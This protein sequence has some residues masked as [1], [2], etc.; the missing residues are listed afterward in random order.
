[1]IFNGLV[2]DFVTLQYEISTYIANAIRNLNHNDNLTTSVLILAISFIYGVVHAAGP[3]HG[4]AV[5]AFYFTSNKGSYKEA[6]KIGYMISIIHAISGLVTTFAIYFTMRAFFRQQFNNVSVITMKISA[7]LIMLIGLY[8]IYEAYKNKKAKENN[9]PK[10]N[11]SKF[12]VALS[13][14]IVPCPGVM[15]IV[16]FS[17]LLK[18]FLLGILAA[19]FMS[20]GMGITISIAGILSIAANKKANSFLNEKGYILEMFGAF[21]VFGLGVFLWFISHN[22]I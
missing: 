4:K 20:I 16:L 18:H 14:G 8:L 9:I 12:A 13:I 19:V 7:V 22:Q 10:K 21:L 1:M 2:N 15:S 3:G 17:I 11:K 6:F 5:V